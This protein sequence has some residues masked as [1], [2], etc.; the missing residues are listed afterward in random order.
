MII[1][2]FLSAAIAVGVYNHLRKD[3]YVSGGQNVP[4]RP[5]G[6]QIRQLLRGASQSAIF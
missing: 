1:G 2:A 6:K 5:Q 3:V 4:G